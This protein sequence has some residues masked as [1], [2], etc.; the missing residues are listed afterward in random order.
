MKKN[1]TFSLFIL[2]SL[3][4]IFLSSCSQKIEED[5]NVWN[6]ED[7]WLEDTVFLA[8]QDYSDAEAGNEGWVS[9]I[10]GFNQ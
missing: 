7:S 6:I 2:L 9:V 4:S 10:D 5:I 3:L 1:L 8:E